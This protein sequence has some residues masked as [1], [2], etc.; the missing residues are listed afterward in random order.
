M[1]T[2]PASIDIAASPDDVWA[3]IGTFGGLDTWMAGVDSCVVEGDIRT[4]GT[5]GMEI[6]EKLVS[7]DA[8]A[9]TITYAIVG[10]G[11]PVESHEATISVM[12]TPDGGAHVTWAVGVVPA[13]ATPMFRDIYQGALDHLK[14]HL[15]G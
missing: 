14:N 12:D 5:M 13:E 4:V 11:A 2:D 9:R 7:R 6:Q 1:T 10:E 8:E 3:L 15:E